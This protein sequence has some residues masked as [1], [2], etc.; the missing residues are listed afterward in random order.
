MN[1]RTKTIILLAAVLAAAGCADNNRKAEQIQALPFP[2]VVPPAMIDNQQDMLNY[3]AMNMWNGI[4]DPSRT[5]HS[6]SLHISGVKKDDV[7]QKFA[8]WTNLLELA[9][10]ET[11]CKAVH[12]LYDRAVAC[13]KKDTSSN[14]FEEFT[15]LV[16]KYLFDPNSPLRNEDFYG[17]YAEKMAVCPLLDEARKERYAREARLCALNKV[18]TK[19]ADFRFSDKRGKIRRLYDIKA[20]HIVLFFSNPGCKACLEIINAIKGSEYLSNAVKEG[21]LAVLNIYIDE[22]LDEWRSYMP[23]YPE[24]WYNGFDPDY[25]IRTDQLYN[26]RAIPSLYLLDADKKVMLKDA[27]TEKLFGVLENL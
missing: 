8:N 9:G 2:D 16:N 20:D 10:M 12:R 26:V 6:D 23:I 18:G 1:M 13:E 15:K 11:A 25:V 17:A 5:Y 19:A 21:R 3:M 27:T 7:E 4:T 22:D 24:E 14:V